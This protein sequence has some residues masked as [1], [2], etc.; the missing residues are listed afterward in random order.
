MPETQPAVVSYIEMDCT[1]AMEGHKIE[2]GGA[3][4]TDQ[5]IVA[6]IGGNGTLIDWHGKPLGTY[7]A[8]SR[9]EMPR[10]WVSRY[11]YQVEATVDGVV[12]T[13][14]TCGKGMIYRGKL[15]KAKSTTPMYL[16]R[17]YTNDLDTR[18]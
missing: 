17:A 6:Y 15:K 7:K 1:F 3:V 16:S 18:N 13:G 4:V 11:Q 14:R 5:W 8:I 12:Y 10:S 2:A 9:W